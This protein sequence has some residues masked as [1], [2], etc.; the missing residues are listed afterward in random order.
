MLAS[1]ARILE[2]VWKEVLQIRRDKRMF[3]IVLLMPVLE[4]FIFGYVVATEVD[5]VAL[6][7][8]DYSHSAESRPR[9]PA[10]RERLL[11]DRRPCAGSG[12]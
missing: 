10:D 12:T 11:P 2:I 3:G 5:D 8:C 6:A 1:L 9:R 7:V 4:L